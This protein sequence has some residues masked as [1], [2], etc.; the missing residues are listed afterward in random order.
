MIWSISDKFSNFRK[1]LH[2]LATLPNVKYRNRCIYL[3][4]ISATKFRGI[5]YD[6]AVYFVN[7]ICIN[8]LSVWFSIP[9]SFNFDISK[10]WAVFVYSTPKCRSFIKVT[11]SIA[12]LKYWIRNNSESIKYY[13]FWKLLNVTNA[14]LVLL[15][16]I[17]ILNYLI[18]HQIFLC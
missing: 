16:K 10:T 17:K 18:L 13:W 12:F 4:D 7:H 14:R 8:I 15:P 1:C 6:H 9:F 2:R 11:W 5:K 3:R